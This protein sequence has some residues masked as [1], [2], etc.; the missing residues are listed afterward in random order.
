MKR[1]FK[2]LDFVNELA[3]K[4]SKYATRLLTVNNSK[5]S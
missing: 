4:G 2:K 5:H 1:I 3:K